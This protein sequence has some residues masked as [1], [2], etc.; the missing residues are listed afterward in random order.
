VQRAL[1][2]AILFAALAGTMFFTRRIDWYR[3]GEPSAD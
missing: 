2:Y 3:V 1:K